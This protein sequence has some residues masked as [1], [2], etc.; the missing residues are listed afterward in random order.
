MAFLDKLRR[1]AQEPQAPHAPTPREECDALLDEAIKMALQLIA[2]NGNHIPFFL[3]LDAA[4]KRT[5]IAPDDT[6]IRDPDVLFESIRQHILAAIRDKQL[7]AVALAR[8]VRYHRSDDPTPWE[9]IQ[10]TLDHLKDKACTCYLRYQIVDGQVVP[11]ELFATD[12]VEKFFT[13]K[14]TFIAGSDGAVH[15][16]SQT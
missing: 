7:R 5:T 11:G 13:D 12:P 8:N 9:S 14:A 10:V 15:T 2:A 1:M 3:A 16:R 6:Q 4:G